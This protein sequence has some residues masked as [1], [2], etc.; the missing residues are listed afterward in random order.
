MLYKQD[1]TQNSIV[2]ASNLW[3]IW[4][5]GNDD[6][7]F[8]QL[9]L[10]CQ[11]IV[12]LQRH[13]SLIN[14]SIE[15]NLVELQL[16]GLPL[17]VLLNYGINSCFIAQLDN[18]KTLTIQINFIEGNKAKGVL[19]NGV[20]E[21][22]NKDLILSES[23]RVIE[24]NIGLVV[25]LNNTLAKI[26]KVDA[27]SALSAVNSIK[28]VINL[29][30][31]FPD[32][33]LGK[34]NN[35]KNSFDGYGLFSPSG[36]LFANTYP[37][38]PNEAVSSAVKRL[39]PVFKTTLAQK[40]LHLTFNQS[41]SRLPVN[42]SLQINHNNQTFI[43]PQQTSLSQRKNPDNS[44]IN[45]D[46]NPN[47]L[48]I[49]IPLGSQF[50]ISIDNENDHDLYY[51]LLGVNSSRQ[52]MAYFSPHST[53]INGK[54]T[55]SIP[56]NS[57]PLKWIVNNE[58]G[59]GELILICAKSPFNQTL[60]QLYKTTDMTPDNEQILLLENPVSIAKAVL[61]DL[62]LGS[63]ISSNLV[64]NINDVYALDLHNW[65]TFNFVYEIV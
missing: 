40:I 2:L 1:I 17:L 5:I 52:T 8:E 18:E 37:K 6:K 65:A 9:E 56:E 42:V 12:F 21:L 11:N 57:S 32:C 51:L 4:F 50:S 64:S 31:N 54:Q 28:S 22:I 47:N 10:Y 38:V 13:C 26:E 20:K 58:K 53:M 36:V 44:L 61:E 29:G 59:I 16:L 19:I 60:N 62:H 63:K 14:S 30:D 24:R 35:N 43:T 15:P 48:L 33:I 23:L 3:E 49:S 25:A 45:S 41:S 7:L 55:I 39:T 34:F 27:T 46:H